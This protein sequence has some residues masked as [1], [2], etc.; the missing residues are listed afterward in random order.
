MWKETVLTIFWTL[1]VSRPISLQRES[2]VGRSPTS[3]GLTPAF[4]PTQA[5]DPKYPKESSDMKS[6]LFLLLAVAAVV[7]MTGCTCCNWL[8]GSC[9]N[10]PET[11]QSCDGCAA[12]GACDP[13]IGCGRLGCHGFGGRRAFAPGPPSGTI[14]YPYYTTRGP[15]D[16]LAQNP[17]GIGP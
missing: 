9:A 17:P 7:S 8:N 1:R 2:C 3:R 5:N 11:C 14:T 16:F 10:C 13:C 15:R 6:K 12:S 4:Q